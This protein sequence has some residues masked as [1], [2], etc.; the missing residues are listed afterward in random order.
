MSLHTYGP[1]SVTDY[2]MSGQD[3][4][5]NRELVS[6]GSHALVLST[7]SVLECCLHHNDL[8]VRLFHV[9]QG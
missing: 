3:S 1:L 2:L 4:H 9:I 7:T 5:V 6:L 8:P